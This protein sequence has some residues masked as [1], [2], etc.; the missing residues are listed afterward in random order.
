MPTTLANGLTIGYDVVGA[1]PPIVVL[2]AA[3]SSGRRDLG[4]HLDELAAAFLVYLPDARGHGT[5]AWDVTDGF[6]TADLVEDVHAFVDGVGLATFHLLGFSMG[7]MTALHFAASY[8]E[9]LRTLVVAGISPAREPRAS[10]VRRTLDPNRIDRDDPVWATDLAK[11][12]DPGGE[13]GAWRRLLPAIAADV[14]AQPLLTPAQLRRIGPPTLVA[15]GDRDPFVPVGQAAALARDLPDGRLL[16]APDAGHEVMA[17]RPEVFAA[18]LADF[19]RGTAP[20]AR[21]RAEHRPEVA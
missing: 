18:A 19:Y 3:T 8:P 17:E 6:D 1:G 21:R 15:V 7:A 2:H 10:M 12:H 13:T 20:I 16:V 5:T 9:R 4:S 11:R 14:A